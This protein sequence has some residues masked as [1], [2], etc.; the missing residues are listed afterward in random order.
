MTPQH[1]Q[2]QQQLHIVLMGVSGS[3]KT[4][5]ARALAEKTQR[6]LLEAD[7]L[8]P[9][10][11]MAVLKNGKM[12][13]AEA[14]EA[15]MQKVRSW[16]MEHA[17]ARESTVVA[18]TA[19][20]LA[21]REFLNEVPGIVFYVH[22]FGTEDVLRDRMARRIGAPLP[23]ELLED[24]LAMLQNLRPDELGIQLDVK[25]SPE[26]LADD[27]LSAANFAAKAYQ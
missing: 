27:A 10:A 5:V 6:P 1:E 4:T 7:D 15:W 11:D 3:G 22:L 18:C 14:R 8:H 9:S 23:A 26:Q 25:R 24:Q 17:E 16:M 20:K 12:P 13:D 19:L 21:H 2:T